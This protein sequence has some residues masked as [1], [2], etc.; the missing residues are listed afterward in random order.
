[1]EVE[2]GSGAAEVSVPGWHR[3]RPSL[4]G[5]GPWH[6]L[7]WLHLLCLTLHLALGRGVT[8][9]SRALSPSISQRRPGTWRIKPGL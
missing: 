6:L 5:V 3:G 2:G 4:R 1:M 8:S 7:A 9:L